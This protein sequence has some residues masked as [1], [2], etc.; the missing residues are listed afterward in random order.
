MLYC[1]FFPVYILLLFFR[2]IYAKITPKKNEQA[3]KRA[4]V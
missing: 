1:A 4:W 2:K 3:K